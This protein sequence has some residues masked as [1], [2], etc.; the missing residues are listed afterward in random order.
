LTNQ[1]CSKASGHSPID[2][3]PLIFQIQ[4]LA[5]LE[6]TI[7]P[8]EFG[9]G[10]VGSV[11]Q[12]TAPYTTN[13]T[14]FYVNRQTISA[15]LAENENAVKKNKLETVTSEMTKYNLYIMAVQEARWDK[16]GSQPAEGYTQFYGN[17]VKAKVKVSLC[18]N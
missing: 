9:L 5:L 2:S 18:F 14:V 1:F 4:L 17:K 6:I 11:K 16:D 7:E 15:S 13:F 3:E 10:R 8:L 12:Y